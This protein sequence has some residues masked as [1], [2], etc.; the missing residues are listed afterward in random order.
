MAFHFEDN[1]QGDERR[2]REPA[3]PE[4]GGDRD[5]GERDPDRSRDSVPPGD[6]HPGGDRDSAEH[7]PDRS[8]S[9]DGRGP[10]GRDPAP[11]EPE[12]P[13]DPK[14]FGPFDGPGPPDYSR[15]EIEAEL[16]GPQQG[17]FERINNYMLLLLA[18]A[19]FFMYF[20]VAGFLILGNQ[21]IL[22]LILPGIIA[23]LL[24]LY[25]LTK[26]FSL[27]FTE[28]YRLRVPETFLA[29][30][31]VLI[32]GSVVLPVDVISSYCDRLWPPDADYIEFL[33]AIK[34]KGFWGFVG[35]AVGTVLVAPA[36]E[37]LIFRGV[38][39]RIFQ[40]N[41]Q[42][43]IAVLL[44]SLV[45]GLAHFDMAVIPSVTVLGFL[46]GYIFLRTGNL[47]YPMIG[48]GLYNLA[49]LI[50]LHLTPVDSLEA[51]EVATSSSIWVLASLLALGLGILLLESR[52]PD[53]KP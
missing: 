2:D 49:S 47:L 42:G 29:A 15:G 18:V 37:E 36:T 23:F 31:T 13:G 22:S 1:D 53:V 28:E 10:G 40:R 6:D 41:M 21:I 35:V 4:T 26:R 5:S 34:P 52:R 9:G 25:A 14:P 7:D 20:S 43:W 48:H 30:V 11:G 46:F 3:R 39:Q 45:F 50:R 32:A 16:F 19:C 12:T 38:I 24:P 8:E 27:R 17:L 51:G 33:L 44:S